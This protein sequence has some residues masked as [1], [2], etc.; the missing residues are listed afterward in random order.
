[1]S[2]IPGS[3]QEKRGFSHFVKKTSPELEGFYA[4][5]FW[6][7]LLLQASHAEPALRHAVI[8]ISSLHE[9]FAGRSL[10][11][12]AGRDDKFPFA[13]NQYT[14]AIGHLRRSLAAGK[15]A[16]LTALMSCILFV[17]FDSFRGYYQTAMVHLQ[18]GMRI[19]RDLRAQS[20]P[21][22]PLIE[23]TI[24]P[25]LLRLGLQ[26]ILYID[27]SSPHDRVT[28]ATE[29]TQAVPQ[30]KPVPEMFKSLE[31]A[32]ACMN[33]CCDGLFRLFYL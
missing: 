22:D 30:N 4:S 2:Q 9:D 15:Q 31:E 10:G 18:S 21:L 26:S 25:L 6:D 8:A 23:E 17:C 29:L 16:P 33:E 13:L 19:L 28:F 32:R 5:G 14:K 20:A 7:A 1:M 11:P 27:T 24:A 3:T 12:S